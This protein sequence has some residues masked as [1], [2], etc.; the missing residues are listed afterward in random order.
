MTTSDII[1]TGVL[2][3]LGLLGAK[4]MLRW[5]SG[6]LTGLIAACLLLA[7]LGLLNQFQWF[8]NA[9]RGCFSGGHAVP[10]VTRQV[11]S[12]ANRCGLRIS[13]KQPAE[14][15]NK[16]DARDESVALDRQRKTEGKR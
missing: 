9:T 7:V 16:D 11:V 6:A 15:I 2:F 4:G 8:S 14:E 10:S 1:A 5:V 12:V 3:V 13:Y